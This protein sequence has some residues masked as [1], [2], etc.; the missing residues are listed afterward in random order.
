MFNQP[1]LSALKGWT[2]SEVTELKSVHFPFHFH[3]IF[4]IS[5][6]TPYFHHKVHAGRNYNMY[7]PDYDIL[8]EH[9]YFTKSS[10]SQKTHLIKPIHFFLT[11]QTKIF[12]LYLCRLNQA[13]RLEV[14]RTETAY[15]V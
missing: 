8:L 11:T 12:N 15:T 3:Y 2:E 13:W 9:Q 7:F 1:C 6:K 4:I 5:R 10:I 14:Q